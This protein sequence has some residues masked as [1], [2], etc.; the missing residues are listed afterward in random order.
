MSTFDHSSRLNRF[1]AAPRR[2]L[3]YLTIPMMVGMSIQ[4]IYMIADMV[5]V[6]RVSAE[7]LTALA[8]NMPLAFLAIGIV[9]GLGSG[10]TAVIA[11]AVGEEDPAAAT[12]GALHAAA[13]GVGLGLT[14]TVV[15]LLWGRELLGLLGVPAE[16]MPLAW[17]YFRILASGYLFLVMTVFFRSMLAGEGDVRIPVA[18][19]GSGTLLNLALDPLFIFAFGLGVKGAALATVISQLATTIAFVILLVVRRHPVI[20][21]GL[22]SFRFDREILR[23]IVGIGLPASFSF[24]IMALGGGVFNRI[25]VGYSP[26]AVAAYQ[27]GSRVDHVYLLPVISMAASLV[28]LVGMF[29]GARRLDLVRELLTYALLRA[30]V[31]ALCLG[32][33]FFVFAPAIVG[34]FTDS[35]EI[36]T[37][38]SSYLRVMVFSYPFVAVSMLAGRSLQGMGKGLPVMILTI[39][40]VLLIGA[41]LAALAAHFGEPIEWVWA[42]IVAGTVTTSALAAAWLQTGL[43]RL[44]TAASEA[45]PPVPVVAV[46]A[47]AD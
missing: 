37:L 20:T 16:L 17:D 33:L 28:T 46:E 21:S 2:A 41:P 34:I 12:S 14:F 39:L 3:W 25:L 1:L 19:Q 18:I 31:L 8:F 11:Q 6:G 7:A 40:R 29:Y 44:M 13:F 38:G 4:T 15:G 22:R 32:A 47:G 36:R 24:V 43:R 42:A 5:F 30:V 9:F 35:A 26:G 10:V 27:V 45:E 23:R